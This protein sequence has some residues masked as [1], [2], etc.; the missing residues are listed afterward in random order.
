MYLSLSVFVLFSNHLGGLTAL[1]ALGL[2]DIFLPRVLRVVQGVQLKRFAMTPG[3]DFINHSSAVTGYA[4]V[5]YQYFTEGFVVQSGE[6]Y[7]PGDQVFISYG[8]QSNDPF[9]QYYGF[10]EE[11]NPAETYTFGSEVSKLLGVGNGKLVAKR[12]GFLPPVVEAVSKR[13]GGKKEAALEALRELCEAELNGMPTSIEEDEGLLR[14][15]EIGTKPRLDLAIR[16]RIEKKSMLRD[17][18]KKSASSLA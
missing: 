12:S 1:L 17:L 5:S 7:Q 9:L 2:Y 3:I 18:A 4:E 8:A 14:D 16:Y 15:T 10:I 11:N 6:N 13:L